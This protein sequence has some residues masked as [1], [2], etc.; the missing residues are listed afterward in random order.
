MPA[1][2][3][4]LAG[5]R[6]LEVTTSLAGPYCTLILGALGAD[7]VKVEPPGRGDDTRG[8]GPPF[9][10]GESAMYL[11]ANA[12]KRSLALDLRSPDGRA[13]VLRLAERT[14]VFVQNLRPGLID[15][16]G[17]GFDDVSGRNPRV[18][19]CS[20]GAFGARGPLRH[21]PGYDPLMQAAGGIMSVTGEP[22]GPPLRAGV[23]VVDQAT[24]MW[25]VIAVLAALRARDEGAAAQLV[26]LSLYETAVSW[27]PYQIAGYLASGKIPRRL[28]SAL[29]II[30]P[31]QA[32][33]AADGWLMVAAG[34]DRLF[35][36]LCRELDVPELADDPRF[37]TNADRVAHRDELASLLAERFR[38]E[39]WATWLAR[40]RAAGVPAAPIQDVA[41]VV[42]DE[43]TAALG[44][45]QELSH[46]AIPALRLVAPPV[47]VDE[48]RLSY[49]RRPP[50]LGEHSREV[51]QEA[52]YS[53]REIDAILASDP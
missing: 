21:D 45:L 44:L 1:R 18:V 7:V 2:F 4:P 32:F 16:L 33:P 43:Q 38:A 39:P 12:G 40:L 17:L 19:Y 3:S 13:A 50:A 41:E 8:W 36:A 15:R 20:I 31:Y 6:V 10:N 22:D 29:G 11:A 51:L 28:G 30:A 52:G 14:D 25:G 5:I 35:A 27:L 37:R 42:A 9:W 49:G 26:D 34:N 53:E 46:P 24:G 48:E 47:S 23:S